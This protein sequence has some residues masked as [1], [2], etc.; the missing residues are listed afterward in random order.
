MGRGRSGDPRPAISAWCREAPHGADFQSF[1]LSCPD[2]LIGP[3]PEDQRRHSGSH[4]CGCG[5]RAT[6][7][8]DCAASGKDGRVVHCAYNFYVCRNVVR[9]DIVCSRAN[10]RSFAQL[11]AGRAD[12]GDRVGGRFDRHAAK[13]EV[14][15]RFSSGNPRHGLVIGIRRQLHRQRP[16]NGRWPAH[17]DHRCQPGEA[18]LVVGLDL[19]RSALY[20]PL[21]GGP[22]DFGRPNS[23]RC[24]SSAS[25]V[26]RQCSHQIAEIAA[27][28]SGG[29]TIGN[30]WPLTCCGR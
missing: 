11:R 1:D 6:V 7:V 24:A 3:D 29:G 5:A 17:S 30:R 22:I 12:H 9:G 20:D 16:T 27:R 2:R 8:D 25:F 13:T 10:Q 18:E 26:M 4:A 21:R 15:R 23:R 19:E 28:V 14:D